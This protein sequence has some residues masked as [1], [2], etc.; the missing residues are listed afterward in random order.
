[1]KVLKNLLTSLRS[2]RVRRGRTLSDGV[3]TLR[4]RSVEARGGVVGVDEYGHK[5]GMDSQWSRTG[6][7]VRVTWVHVQVDIRTRREST[8]TESDTTKVRETRDSRS[9]STGVSKDQRRLK[10]WGIYPPYVEGKTQSYLV[11]PGPG[12]FRITYVHS[13][14]SDKTSNGDIKF[15]RLNALS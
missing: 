8:T 11:D 5:S 9:G 15:F 10:G 3:L 13:L 2:H 4:H 1:M 6:A 14:C 12:D 7:P